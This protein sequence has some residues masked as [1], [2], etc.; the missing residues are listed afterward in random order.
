MANQ[1]LVDRIVGMKAINYSSL[2][3]DLTTRW[4]GLEG[5]CKQP[6]L[7]YHSY[8]LEMAKGDPHQDDGG[9]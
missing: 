6:W 4:A 8:S 9:N 7:L 2:A 5:E 3:S 1:L